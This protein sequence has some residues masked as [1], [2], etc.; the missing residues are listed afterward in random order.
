MFFMGLTCQATLWEGI[1][2]F[3]GYLVYVLAVTQCAN[4][5]QGAT[6]AVVTRTRCCC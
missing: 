2:L 6:R 4:S 3:A 1:A 5:L